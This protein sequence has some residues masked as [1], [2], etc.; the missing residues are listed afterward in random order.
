MSVVICCLPRCLLSRSKDDP[1]LSALIS[2]EDPLS[3]FS[4]HARAKPLAAQLYLLTSAITV[5]LPT[6]TSLLLPAAVA[7]PDQVVSLRHLLALNRSNALCSFGCTTRLSFGGSAAPFSTFPVNALLCFHQS[8]AAISRRST[9]TNNNLSLHNVVAC[10][11]LS[12]AAH[13]YHCSPV[14]HGNLPTATFSPPSPLF[15]IAQPRRRCSYQPPEALCLPCHLVV[16]A[17]SPQSLP[18][19][20]CCQH[21]S[22]KE[23]HHY[24]P[25]L[26]IKDDPLVTPHPPIAI[27]HSLLATANIF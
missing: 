3:R 23:H 22:K 12:P 1:L 26:A 18:F 8:P 17:R 7:H 13:R 5:P 15:L 2:P 10:S 20:P 16:A 19:P 4:A 14:F 9:A 11:N 27:V 21:F 6:V 24:L 25:S